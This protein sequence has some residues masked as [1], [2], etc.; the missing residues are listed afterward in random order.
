ME[1]EP[2]AETSSPRGSAGA[3]GESDSAYISPPAP[4]RWARFNQR[5]N[6][7]VSALACDLF[8]IAS[9]LLIVIYYGRLFFEYGDYTSD[10]GFLDH[11]LHREL[12]WFTKVTLFYPG[13]PDLYRIALLGLGALGALALT[14]GWKPKAGALL[15]WVVSVSVHRWNFAVINVDDSSITLLLWW[16][17]FLP[18]GRTLTWR[19][20]KTGWRSEVPLRAEGFFVRA[21]FVNL[22]IYYLTTGLTKTVSSLWSEGLALFVVLKLPLAR[23]NEF[24][25]LEHIPILWFGN[26]FTLIFE[27]LFPFLILLRPWHPLKLVGAF[28]WVVFHLAIPLS[29]GVPYANLTLIIALILVF[30]QEIDQV[31]RRRAN[32]GSLSAEDHSSPR[33]EPGETVQGAGRWARRL[34]VV[35][36]V[37]LALAMTKKIPVVGAVYEPAMATLYW[38]GIAQEYHLFDWID[39]FN[40]WVEH[41]VAMVPDEGAEQPIASRELFP[42]TVRGFIV[43][44]YLLPMRWM[45]IPRPLT[46]EMRISVLERAAHRLVQ[47]HRDLF[48]GSGEVTVRSR[49]GRL[50]QDNLDLHDTWG[51]ELLRFRYLDGEVSSISVPELLDGD[52]ATDPSLEG[53]L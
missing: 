23:T 18:I 46:G 4:G 20:L 51:F 5:W 31:F 43:Q 8:R 35:Y 44:S 38:G 30:H 9:G 42:P 19:T 16:L 1:T 24:W 53:S 22:W 34:I 15:C 2:P 10:H 40:W 29:I 50:T 47:R 39:R 41:E 45:R 28:F 14:V 7:P 33:G 37:V 12:F 3:D 26:H 52:I 21:F 48:Q 13:A 27:P 25:Q 49:V 36:L 11:E 32:E 17:L 6:T